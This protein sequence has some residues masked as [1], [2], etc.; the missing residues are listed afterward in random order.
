MT[1][2][3]GTISLGSVTPSGFRS[4]Y[5]TLP[6]AYSPEER[7]EEEEYHV[8]SYMERSLLSTHL[9]VHFELQNRPYW[10][11]GSSRFSE[12]N[13]SELKP[14]QPSVL[15]YLL[16]IFVTLM[17]ENHSSSLMRISL[18]MLAPQNSYFRPVPRS[19]YPD[20]RSIELRIHKLCRLLFHRVRER[21]VSES[22]HRLREALD[23]SVRT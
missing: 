11:K 6:V 5:A 20:V 9:I 19:S 7:I 8:I 14:L 17:E 18:D 15:T 16:R 10:S 22:W 1:K 23:D 12:L 2:S 3:K 21:L 4:S 13:Y